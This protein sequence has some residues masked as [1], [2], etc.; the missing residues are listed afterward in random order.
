MSGA[1]PPLLQYALMAWCSIKHRDNFTYIFSSVG[2]ALGYGLDDQGS[3][4]RFRG[5]GGN[6]A[7]EH[8]VQTG[9]GAHPASFVGGT[10]GS[11]LGDRAA[12]A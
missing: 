2:I 9:S 6:F 8:R 10:R 4:V 5:G 3:R 7:L 12:G 1:I 11:L